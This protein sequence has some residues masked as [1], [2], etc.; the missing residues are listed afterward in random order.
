[1][2]AGMT[3]A[4]LTAGVANAKNSR[5][6]IYLR[7]KRKDYV[8]YNMNEKKVNSEMIFDRDEWKKKLLF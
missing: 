8:K 6:F 7:G 3:P 4:G 2:T 5:L 1:M